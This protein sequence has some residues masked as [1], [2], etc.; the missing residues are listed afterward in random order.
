MKQARVVVLVAAVGTSVAFAAET[1]ASELFATKIQPVFKQQCIGCHG[2]GQTLAKL[3]LRTP[4]ALL[5]GGER[6]PAVVPA[7]EA[8]EHVD[9]RRDVHI[10]RHIGVRGRDDLFGTVM[11]VGVSHY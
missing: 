8:H 2:E 6:G 11:L 3:D 7:R 10:R 9:E 4:E 1:G 5:K